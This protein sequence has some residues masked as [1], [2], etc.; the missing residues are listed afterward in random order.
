MTLEEVIARLDEFSAEHMIY[1]EAPEPSA[2]AV[3]A[4]DGAGGDLP[5][6]LEV[7]LAR[8]AID[9]WSQWRPGRSPTHADKVAAVTHYAVHDAW[10]PVE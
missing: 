8:E 9:V 5:Y 4:E 1:A 7:A 6:L 2:R 10:L 3:V